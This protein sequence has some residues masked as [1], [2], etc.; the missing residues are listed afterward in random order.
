[1]LL[2]ELMTTGLCQSQDCRSEMVNTY[3]FFFIYFADKLNINTLQT[4]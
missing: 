1:M 4:K 3:G 2:L